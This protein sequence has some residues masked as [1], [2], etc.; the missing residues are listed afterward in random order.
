MPSFVNSV[1]LDGL[2]QFFFL[3]PSMGLCRRFLSLVAVTSVE[4]ALLM[5]L[6]WT[7]SV[8]N[9]ATEPMNES[10]RDALRSLGQDLSLTEQSEQ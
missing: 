2:P 6:V 4:I 3:G 8:S 7:N 5:S 9:I 1:F 10:E